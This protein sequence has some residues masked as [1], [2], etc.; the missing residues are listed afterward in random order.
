MANE[1]I[2]TQLRHLLPYNV[3]LYDYSPTNMKS[4]ISNYIRNYYQLLGDNCILEDMSVLSY[5]IDAN[6]LVTIRMSSGFVIEDLTCIQFTTTTTLTLDVTP[7]DQDGG[8]LIVNVGYENLKSIEYNAPYM[9]LSYIENSGA[10][11]HP[12][13]WNLSK[14]NLL[15]G[16]FMFTK[17]PT[18]TITN[19]TPVL[20]RPVLNKTI[21][22]KLYRIA[23]QDKITDKI[24]SYFI[25]GLELIQITEG[26]VTDGYVVLKNVP[27]DV[28][29][30]ET[31]ILNGPVL[32]NKKV[33][34]LVTP[35][36]DV[37]G[38][39]LFFKNGIFSNPQ[40]TISGL[41]TKYTLRVGDIIK[42]E[43]SY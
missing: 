42:I 12:I 17:S 13:D 41:A 33:T 26:H 20:G 5:T 35:D 4:Y 3:S 27:D 34:T 31:S 6:D 32:V 43:Y 36:Y 2:P 14:D 10:Y 9:K 24:M 21:K 25:P 1:I 37:Y 11:G 39:R 19:L 30:I 8:Y 23:P 22:G 38:N 15:I 28:T 7:Y 16:Y 18:K 40:V 29:K